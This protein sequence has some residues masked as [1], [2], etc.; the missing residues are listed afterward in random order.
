MIPLRDENPSR[1]YPIVTL[2]LIAANIV[3]F[4]TQL[5]FGPDMESFVYHFALVPAQVTGHAA[6]PSVGFPGPYLSILTSMFLH[7]GFG[8][9]IGNMWFLWI[10][11]DN[12]EDILGHS[13]FLLF[14][15]VSG[16]AAGLLHVALN[17]LSTIPTLG[18]SG[19]ISG[20]LGAYLIIFPST[21][22]RTLIFLGFFVDIINIPALFFLGFWF[23]MQFLGGF[24]SGSES[25]I[26]FG[27]H[28]GG[29]IAGIALVLLLTRRTPVARTYRYEPKRIRRW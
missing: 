29:F 21:R 4:F 28:I 9:L 2:G 13:R 3:V 22:V 27:A 1:R 20:V 26:A 25:G 12:I 7:G 10:F 11:G 23:L 15:L 24:M 5:S 8:H 16:V 18:A 6:I 17:P 19:A 14:Y